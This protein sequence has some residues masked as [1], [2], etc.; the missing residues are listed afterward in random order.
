MKD[1]NKPNRDKILNTFNNT[2][3]Y[4]ER[5]KTIQILFE[6]QVSRTPD[7]I[8]VEFLHEKITYSDLNL[9]ANQLA[10]KLRKRGVKPNDFV[11]VIVERS[12]ELI[13]AILA[14]LKSGGAYVPIDPLYPVERIQYMLKNCNADTIIT[15]RGFEHKNDMQ[16]KNIFLLENE[17]FNENEGNLPEVNSSSDLS[18]MIYTSGSTG[19]PKGIMLEHRAT[20]NFIVGMKRILDFSQI[21]SIASLTSV[22][23]DIFVFESLL[24]LTMGLKVIIANVLNFEDYVKGKKVDLIQT[25]PSTMSLLLKEESNTVYLNDLKYLVIGG[26]SFPKDLLYKIRKVTSAVVYNMYGPTETSVWSTVKKVEEDNVINIGKPIAN[27]RIYILGEDYEL[28]EIGVPGDLYIAGDGLARGYT[29]IEQTVKNFIENPYLKGERIYKTGDIAKWLSNGEIEFL[30]RADSQVKIRGFRIELEEIEQIMKKKDGITDCVV[31]AQDYDDG[32]KYLI[33]YYISEESC[34]VSDLI[35]YMAHY[36]PEYMVPGYFIRIDNFPLTPNGKLNKRAL[37]LPDKE[38]PELKTLYIPPSSEIELQICELWKNILSKEMIGVDDNFFELGGNSVL[39]VQMYSGLQR[40]YPGY[41]TL[42]DIFTYP[43]IKKLCLYLN[44]AMQKR[45]F[46]KVKGIMFPETYFIKKGELPCFLSFQYTLKKNSSLS[47]KQQE[48]MKMKQLASL[49]TSVLSFLCNT[50]IVNIGL[51]TQEEEGIKFLTLDF[52]KIDTI[53]SIYSLYNEAY[54]KARKTYQ[55]DEL[56]WNTA[57]TRILTPLIMMNK[58]IKDSYVKAFGL[59]LS[60]KEQIEAVDIALEYNS[61]L[62]NSTKVE[63]LYKQFIKLVNSLVN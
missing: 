19:N 57:N 2:Y 16:V 23:F 45:K 47:N 3:V 28:K 48:N 63:Y 55:L 41:I 38:R 30:G 8:A 14:V 51:I 58:P 31:T 20:H 27:T 56:K 40:M 7:N 33:C 4:Y 10:N 25:T 53:E 15:Q 42:P 49:F 24:P 11:M 35:S 61:G 43:T 26:E 52:A 12:I 34:A 17:I 22:S 54:H 50:M 36:L 6:E 37:P 62:L 18:Y 13:I 44:K 21:K 46:Y 32:T 60:I 59:I 39:L 9:K 29:S 5:E 1:I